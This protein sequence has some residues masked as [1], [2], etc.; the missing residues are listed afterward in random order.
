MGL[1]NGG[2]VL[3][4]VRAYRLC[5]ISGK[6]SGGKTSFALYLAKQFLSE[7]Y[8]FITNN[9]TIWADALEDV[10][11]YPGSHPKYANHLRAVV[12]LDEGGLYFK[13]GKQIEQIAAYAAKMD[14]IYILPSFWPPAREVQVFNI[15][16]LFSFQSS[17]VP[18][19]VYVWK[20]RLGNFKEGGW[21]AWFYPQE[22]YGTY[23]RQDPG[24]EP[25]YIVEFL[26][27][28]T[29]EFRERMGRRTKGGGDQIPILEQEISE[30]DLLR[31]IVRSL[32]E[33]TSSFEAVSVRGAKS[34]RK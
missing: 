2:S 24:A 12:V 11:L 15:Q 22:V 6:F 3:E 1:I 14:A 33:A 8:R 23:S 4:L 21:F 13:S 16:P 17:G 27:R 25:E 30:A 26:I 5:W 34:R 28:R 9:S 31:D 19:I 29:Q 32:D 7:G 20:V 10:Q 18:L